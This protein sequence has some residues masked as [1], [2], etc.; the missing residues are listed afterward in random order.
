L[1]TVVAGQFFAYWTTGTNSSIVGAPTSPEVAWTAGGVTGAYQVFEQ[2]MVL[3]SE[4]TGT[5]AVLDGPIRT[6]WGGLGGSG[7]VLGWP[8]SDRQV[9]SESVTQRFQRGSV[10]V[11][12]V[13]EPYAILD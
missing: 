3:S 12:T 2:A 1:A 10:V 9:E 4:A 8:V 7:G 11:P 13:G 6:V 5:Y